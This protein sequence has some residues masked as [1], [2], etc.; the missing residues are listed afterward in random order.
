[1]AVAVQHEPAVKNALD[2]VM[3]SVVALCMGLFVYGMFRYPDAPI[4]PCGA[5]FCGKGNRPHTEEQYR[6]FVVWET[7]LLIS[8][9]FGFAAAFALERRSRR[10]AAL[11]WTR[12][13]PLQADLPPMIEEQ[14]YRA[15]WKDL[16][17][18][19]W[20]ARTL[21]LPALMSIGWALSRGSIPEGG[22]FG[23]LALFTLAVCS[24]LRYLFFRCPRCSNQYFMIRNVIWG[25]SGRCIHCGLRRRMTFAQ[26]LVE[27]NVST[28][29]LR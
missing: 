28:N 13:R 12:L 27:L 24:N 3:G 26:S 2:F 1:V 20:A 14:R 17:R 22:A 18:R 6:A 29:G 15:A 25:N 16:R 7:A 4:H 11:A 5:G 8:W 10:R 19:D 9:P 21:F 23:S